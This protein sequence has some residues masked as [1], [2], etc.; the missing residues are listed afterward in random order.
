MSAVALPP[1]RDAARRVLV[2]VDRIERQ[3]AGAAP[4]TAREAGARRLACAIG[5][6]ASLARMISYAEWCCSAGIDAESVTMAL[7]C[8]QLGDRTGQ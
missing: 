6:T 5:R 7:R 2:E 4:G 3:V 1:L 8:V